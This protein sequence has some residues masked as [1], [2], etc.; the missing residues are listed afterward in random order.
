MAIDAVIHLDRVRCAAESDP[1]RSEPYAWTALIA[2]DLSSFETGE[3]VVSAP[4]V[5][6]GSRTVI[7]SGMRAGD[8]ASMPSAQRRFE[9]HFGDE[10][11]LGFVGIVVAMLDDNGM[12]GDAVRAGYRA[13]L[14]ELKAEVGT[15]LATEGEP[16]EE[17]LADL[18]RK[19][20]SKV[21]L[22]VKRNLSFWEKVQI[23]VG[24]GDTDDPLG[25]DAEFISFI[26]A[27]GAGMPS[28]FTLTFEEKWKGPSSVQSPS[29]APPILGPEIELV[30]NH[31]EID[32]RFELRDV[33]DH[34]VPPRQ[35]PTTPPQPRP[36]R[37]PSRP[38]P[39]GTSEP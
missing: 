3:I 16:N 15:L 31:Y 37:V 30:L 8:Q 11:R 22:A 18:G 7:N 14:R 21:K 32:G 17:E 19:I 20:K 39:P 27:N 12:P 34:R 25:F 23:G 35:P 6:A 29:N 2:G 4:D 28:P 26:P 24:I 5:A 13:F 38:R 33:R 1:G 9:H 36:P 10:S